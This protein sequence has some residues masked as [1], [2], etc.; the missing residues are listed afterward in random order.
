MGSLSHPLTLLHTGSVTLGKPL[1][2]SDPIFCREMG[3]PACFEGLNEIKE[4]THKKLTSNR[5]LPPTSKMGPPEALHHHTRATPA[6]LICPE[7][8]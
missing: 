7:P 8:P 1:Y 6:Q 5:R 4:L 2:L 3:T